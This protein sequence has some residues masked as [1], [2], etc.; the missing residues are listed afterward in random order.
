MVNEC[1]LIPS[2][3]KRNFDKSDSI[4]ICADGSKLADSCTLANDSSTAKKSRNSRDA[5]GNSINQLD[6]Q[7]NDT[8]VFEEEILKILL[9]L[10]PLSDDTLANDTSSNNVGQSDQEFYEEVGKL[11][12]DD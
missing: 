8:D 1:L 6:E 2:K 12:F 4:G 3:K 11:L 9:N 10:I 7:Y 5:S